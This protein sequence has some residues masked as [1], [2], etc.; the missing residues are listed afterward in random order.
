LILQPKSINQK[1]Y[2]TY[3]LE[4]RAMLS[5]GQTENRDTF[6]LQPTWRRMNSC[7]VKGQLFSIQRGPDDPDCL[8]L[9]GIVI[10][11]VPDLSAASG[12]PSLT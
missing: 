12:N 2:E 6:I 5:P 10:V 1:Q 11:S 4:G 7:P 8:Q 9:H 3:P